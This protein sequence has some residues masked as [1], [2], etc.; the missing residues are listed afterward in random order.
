MS[1]NDIGIDLGTVSVLIYKPGEGITLR[2]PSVVAINSRTGDVLSVGEEAYKMVGRTPE[3]IRAVYPLTG[4]TIS[5]FK[6]TEEMIRYFI[7]RSCAGSP[8]KPRVCICVPSGITDVESRAVMD[9]AVNV[10]ARKVYLI[11]EPV[12]AA[13]GADIDISQP[14]GHLI[15]DIGGGTTDI[16]V[17]SLN[18][19]VL[20]QSVKVAGNNFNEAIVKYIRNTHNILIGEK[21]ADTM[22]CE[23]GSVYFRDDEDISFTIKG[24]NLM[25]G[26]P[27]KTEITRSELCPVLLDVCQPIIEALQ[28]VLEE[29]PPELAA[30]IFVNGL[31]M[32]GG[33]SLLHGL[34]QLVKH[35][36]KLNAYVAE[37]PVECVAIGTGKAFECMDDL[38]DGMVEIAVHKY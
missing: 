1:S 15:L 17:L 30:D 37:N 38:F 26:L 22:K 19:I 16:A 20:K 13:L 24:R 2:E 5:D 34:P 9:M 12:A 21:M 31:V 36:T 7:K 4:G 14:N 23:I 10:G 11:E 18:G 32:T 29:T 3:K 27:Q 35:Y 8:I 28:K 6:V 25:T 33:G